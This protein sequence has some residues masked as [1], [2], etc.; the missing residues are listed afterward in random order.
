MIFPRRPESVSA[1]EGARAAAAGRVVVYWRRGCP[2]TQ[3]LVMRLGRRAQRAVW[4]DIW[5][6]PEAA[7]YVRS[8]NGGDET[9]PTVVIEGRAYTNPPPRQVKKA[10]ARTG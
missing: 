10:L 6:D 2:F 8:V 5:A 9:V 1:Q 3:R 7:A 4:V